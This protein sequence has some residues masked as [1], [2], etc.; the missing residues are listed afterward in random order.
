MKGTRAETVDVLNALPVGSI[1]CDTDQVD[2]PRD[3]LGRNWRKIYPNN[4]VLYK[5]DRRTLEGILI[6]ITPDDERRM[7]NLSRWHIYDVGLFLI[8]EEDDPS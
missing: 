6:E 2:R 7:F 5:G 8:Q 3:A 1:L 4:W